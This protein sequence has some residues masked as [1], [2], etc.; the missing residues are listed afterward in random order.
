MKLEEKNIDRWQ[1]GC[2]HQAYQLLGAHPKADGTY[3]AVW[4][5]HAYSV[6]VVGQF[7]NWDG[8]SNPMQKEAST[9][10]WTAFV[11]DI[12]QWALYKYEIK[13][14]RDAPPFLKADPYAVLSEVR[15][16]MASLV[17]QLDGFEWKDDEWI[18]GRQKHQSF[19]KPISIYEVHLASWKRKGADNRT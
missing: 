8:R 19:R 11:P 2:W 14:A 1:S 5:P 10:I 15:P 4:A 9:G 12:G 13:T 6:S 3:F 16:K 18:S 17:Y 7:N